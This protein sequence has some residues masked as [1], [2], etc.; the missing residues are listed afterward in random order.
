MSRLQWFLCSATIVLAI[1]AVVGAQQQNAKKTSPPG[2]AAVSGRVF[3]ITE[4]GDLKP[5]R[6]ANVY[7]LFKGIGRTVPQSS[8]E[9][10]AALVFQEAHLTNLLEAEQAIG[11]TLADSAKAQ[12]QGVPFDQDEYEDMSCHK[13]LLTWD[14]SIIATMKWAQAGKREKQFLFTNADE[15][16][17]FKITKVPAGSYAVVARGQAGINDASWY[18]EVSVKQDQ[19]VSVK[20]ASPA[21]ACR[22]HPASE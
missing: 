18:M 6:L 8:E 7:L 19:E 12:A 17:Y 10:T 13:K 1:V 2:T 16:G 11:R 5:A 22:V 9:A 20:L 15:E 21:R 3:V 4:G 14:Q